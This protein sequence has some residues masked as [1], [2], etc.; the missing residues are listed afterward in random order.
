MAIASKIAGVKIKNGFYFYRAAGTMGCLCTELLLDSAGPW[1]GSAQ[2]PA[3]GE[4]G[5]EQIL[6][7]KKGL[8]PATGTHLDTDPH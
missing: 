2:H 8:F 3:P 6:G 5:Q 4:H 1:V 7:E